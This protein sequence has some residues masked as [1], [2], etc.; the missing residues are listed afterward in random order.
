M[1]PD[2]ENFR[3]ALL[4]SAIVGGLGNDVVVCDPGTDTLSGGPDLDRINAR[5]GVKDT[6]N[7]CGSVS[8]NVVYYGQRIDVLQ[9]CVSSQGTSAGL[10]AA[11]AEK[12]KVELHYEKPPEG[13]LRTHRQGPNTAQWR[14]AARGREGT[15]GHMAP[16]TESSTRRGTPPRSR[17]SGVRLPMKSLI[18][19]TRAGILRG[20][21]PRRRA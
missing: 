20:S 8:G 11:E 7:V 1:A 12:V 17:R 2:L 6:I 14:G 3:G 21:G 5:D 16:A 4:D 18:C 10:T 19:A 13:P 15:Q 9:R